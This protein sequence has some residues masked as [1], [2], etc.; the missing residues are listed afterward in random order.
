MYISSTCFQVNKFN[1]FT[2]MS[3][4]KT[5]ISNWLVLINHKT[6]YLYNIPHS[7]IH[8]CKILCY[9][10]KFLHE[11]EGI[12]KIIVICGLNHFNESSLVV[13]Q[14]N[15]Q[16]VFFFTTYVHTYSKTL[17]IHLCVLYNLGSI[18]R[19]LNMV[20]KNTLVSIYPA[21]EEKWLACQ[22]F[23]WRGHDLCC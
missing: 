4:R 21:I 14:F 11:F 8:V 22:F 10:L 5:F 15:G 17:E 23:G 12:S 18:D 9:K 1:F 16:I 6:S 19:A 20:E 13:N 7:I 3:S 2:W